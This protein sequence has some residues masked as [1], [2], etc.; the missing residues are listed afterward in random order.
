[1]LNVSSMNT[2][3]SG[4]S[5]LT[6]VEAAF[7]SHPAVYLSN[8]AVPLAIDV[9]SVPPVGHQVKVVG[10]TH[11]FGQPLEDVDAEAFA[12]V[13]QRSTSLHHQTET[14]TWLQEGCNQK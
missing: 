7:P 6:V 4:R 2:V 5:L 14:T 13:L 12:A 11:D 3:Q 10:E 1:M 9:L 8:H